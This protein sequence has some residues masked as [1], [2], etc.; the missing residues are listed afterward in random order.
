MAIVLALAW[1]VL[2]RV[3]AVMMQRHAVEVLERVRYFN[4]RRREAGIERDALGLGGAEVDAVAVAHVPEVDRVGAA[5]LVRDDRRLGVPEQGPLGLSEER[6]GL[7][8]G[9]AGPGPEPLQLVL[10]EELADD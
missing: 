9:G 7:D 4:A 2:R 8:V 10:D 5:A 6:V 1:A 3:F